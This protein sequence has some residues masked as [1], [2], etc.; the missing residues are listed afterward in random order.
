MQFLVDIL[1]LWS[2]S[3]DPRIFTDPDPGNQNLADPTDPDPKHCLLVPHIVIIKSLVNTFLILTFCSLMVCT[4]AISNYEFCQI[5]VINI[6][7][8]RHHVV[9]S[10]HTPATHIHPY[11]LFSHYK[12]L[13]FSFK[14]IG[15]INRDE[16]GGVPTGVSGGKE[17]FNMH[18][19]FWFLFKFAW[20]IK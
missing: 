10:V 16:G 6:K 1:P 20:K 13:I 3:S 17:D 18:F 19:L 8:L 11:P 14:T 12:D 2:R 15:L 9:N 5:K 4:L 7:G